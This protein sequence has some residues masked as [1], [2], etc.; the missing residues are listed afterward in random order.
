VG[1]SCESRVLGETVTGLDPRGAIGFAEKILELLDEGRYTATYKYA[2]LLALIDLCLEGTQESG[3]PQTVTTRQLADKIIEL[4]W[5]H[6]IPFAGQTSAVVLRQNTNGQA[7]IVSEIRRFR[8]QH[9]S[10][11]SVPHWESRITAPAAYEKL[12]Q[13][14]EWKLIEMPLPRLQTMGDAQRRFIYQINWEASVTQ[15]DFG[16]HLR[17]GVGIFD[18]RVLLMPGV[19]EYFVQLSGL[20]RPL[21]QRRWAAM[22]AQINRLEESQLDRFMFGADRTPTARI[23]VGLWEIQGR[24]CFYCGDRIS[25]LANAHVDHFVPWSRYPDDSLD[26]FVI[27]D[28]SCNGNKSNSLAAHAHLTQWVLRFAASSIEYTQLGDLATAARW[29]RHAPRSLNVARAI[30]P[31]LPDDARLWLRGKE[32]IPP[33]HLAITAALA[34]AP[35]SREDTN[36]VETPLG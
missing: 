21:I 4:Y 27:A 26:N 33:D 25:D 3:P 18:N 32:F 30:Y 12:V 28:K 2:V 8:E 9:A 35:P 7:E 22:V 31:R 13:R 29:D 6:S 11:P 23:R 34:G 36:R 14:V 24:R 16:S 17:G 5:P 15:R 20:L 1:D 10:A 19:G